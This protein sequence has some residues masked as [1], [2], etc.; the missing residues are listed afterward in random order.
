MI[1]DT[2]VTRLAKLVKLNFSEDEIQSFAEQ[3]TTI[4]NLLDELK[5]V[6]CTNTEPLTSV[7]DHT[8]RLREDTVTSGNIT[9]ELFAGVPYTK[10]NLAKEI[11]CFIV[12]KVVE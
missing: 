10:D 4:A 8:Q 12:P 9:K 5:E 7:C 1:T 11:K 2:E 3:L 6:D